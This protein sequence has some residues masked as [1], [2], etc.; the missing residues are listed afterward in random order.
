VSDDSNGR[1][2]LTGS[3]FNDVYNL[4]RALDSLDRINGN[5]TFVDADADVLSANV[6][7]LSFATGALNI[8]NVETINLAVDAGLDAQLD[9]QNVTEASVI[10]VTGGSGATFLEVVNARGTWNAATF[11]GALSVESLDNFNATGGSLD[12]SLRVLGTDFGGATLNGKGGNDTLA[13][14]NG[15]D[16]FRFDTALGTTGIDTIEDFDVDIGDVLQLENSIFAALTA[17]VAPSFLASAGAP[18]ATDPFNLKYNIL[19]GA[20]YY[21]ADA[22][23]AGAAQQIAVVTF[24]TGFPLLTADDFV[25]T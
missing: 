20:L 5:S 19:N 4:G 18:M 9:M 15:A 23:G 14:G 16:T 8:T 13:G 1:Y 21:D 6:T 24:G 3:N 17:G 12:D 10:N 2:D 11:A 22:G 25:V 7:G